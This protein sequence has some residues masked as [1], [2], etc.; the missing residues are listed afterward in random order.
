MNYS[1]FKLLNYMIL[2]HKK[3]SQCIHI[4]RFFYNSKDLIYAPHPASVF[5]S[6]VVPPPNPAAGP[7]LESSA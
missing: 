6:E 5:A 4:K 7:V 1:Q 3:I 2:Q